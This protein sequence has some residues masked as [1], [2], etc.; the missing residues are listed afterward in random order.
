MY[1]SSA[2]K[3]IITA[4]IASTA[5]VSGALLLKGDPI[6]FTNN[7]H[8]DA[9]AIVVTAAP[10]RS[11]IAIAD[12]NNDGTPDWQ[13]SLLTTT[14]IAVAPE[15]SSYL[16]PDTLTDRFA[17]EFFEQM[18]RNENNGAFGQSPEALVAASSQAL[19]SQAVDTPITTKDITVGSDN[20]SAAL[21]SY[22]ESIAAI[23]QL[24]SETNPQNEVT[25]LESALRAQDEDL[26]TEL[27][28]K[29]AAYSKFLEETKQLIVPSKIVNQHLNLLNSY[30]AL[31]SDITAMRNAF[32]DPMLA[33]LR[34]KRYQDDVFGLTI[35]I[36]TLYTTLTEQGASW[37]QGSVVFN[38]ISISE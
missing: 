5:I 27:D 3:R 30:Q 18:V 37:P 11:A 36:S 1:I 28:G 25:I 33:L 2:Q 21:A 26:L 22:G 35:S 29:I 15:T 31:L 4:I 32:A 7:S 9:N 10:E 34:L 20:S 23:I 19:V 12:S 24:Y 14:P 6:T 8:N 16:P 38:L 17:L 13:E